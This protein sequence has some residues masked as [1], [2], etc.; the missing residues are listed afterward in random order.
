MFKALALGALVFAS[1]GLRMETTKHEELVWAEASTLNDT[2]K[3]WDELFRKEINA[4][5]DA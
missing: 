3:Q 2:Q 1:M 5:G 4:L